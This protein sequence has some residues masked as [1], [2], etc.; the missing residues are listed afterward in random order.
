MTQ[1]TPTLSASAA[2]P[3]SKAV[4]LPF[5]P[6]YPGHLKVLVGSLARS[7]GPKSG[8]SDF[9]RA[10]KQCFDFL[11]RYWLA[12][13][14]GSALAQDP[15][16]SEPVASDQLLDRLHQ[17]IRDWDQRPNVAMKQVMRLGFFD[18]PAQANAAPVPKYHSAW[19]GLLPASDSDPQAS[20]DLGDWSAHESRI[21]SQK[22]LYLRVLASFL[23]SSRALFIKYQR[24]YVH[25]N[26]LQLSLSFDGK[27]KPFVIQ[28]NLPWL[29]Y[30]PDVTLETILS[31][32]QSQTLNLAPPE[33]RQV[34]TELQQA[35][36]DLLANQGLNEEP[37]MS[38]SEGGTAH[39]ASSSDFQSS[40][41]SIPNATFR[42]QAPLRYPEELFRVELQALNSCLERLTEESENERGDSKEQLGRLLT[43]IISEQIC[44]QIS[45]WKSIRQLL[46][47]E[48]QQLPTT[49][50][51]PELA[52]LH[53]E[54]DALVSDF[55]TYSGRSEG[56]SLQQAADLHQSVFNF[57]YDMG[58]PKPHALFFDLGHSGAQAQARLNRLENAE[59]E[60]LQDAL[61]A[62]E[63]CFA[64]LSEGW[65][66]GWKRRRDGATEGHYQ[67]LL[68][69][70]ILPV[71]LRTALPKEPMPSTCRFEVR[72][73]TEVFQDLQVLQQRGNPPH[74]VLDQVT[75]SLTQHHLPSQKVFLVGS[76]GVGKT[77][78]C[79]TLLEE[80][81]SLNLGNSSNSQLCC[82]VYADLK[83]R[84]WLDSLNEALGYH[85]WRGDSRWVPLSNPAMAD[86][87]HQTLRRDHST[88]ATA[89]PEKVPVE[90][91]QADLT[92][93]LNH[94][95]HSLWYRN[96]EMASV[97]RIVFLLDGL[98]LNGE[99]LHRLC[100]LELPETFSWVASVEQTPADLEINAKVKTFHLQVRDRPYQHY[101]L[102]Q[103][104]S[105][106]EAA[107]LQ[108]LVD[109]L[110]SGIPLLQLRL[111]CGLY[112][113]ELFPDP[114]QESSVRNLIE[115][116]V[117][118][119]SFSPEQLQ[120]L[121]CLAKFG[122]L[123]CQ[124]LEK[125]QGIRSEAVAYAVD[126]LPHMFLLSMETEG[127]TQE[128]WENRL[129]HLRLA[130][131]SLGPMLLDYLSV[132][133]FE[134]VSQFLESLLT[135]IE[136]QKD[137]PDYLDF[138]EFLEW[139]HRCNSAELNWRVLGVQKVRQ[140]R[141][142]VCED[143]ERQQRLFRKSVILSLWIRFLDN[144]PPLEAQEEANQALTELRREELL[145]AYSSRALAYRQLGHLEEALADV[146]LSL[147]SFKHAV[148]QDENLLNGLAAAHNRRSEILRDLGRFRE[149]LKDAQH[150]VTH[151]QTV[152]REASREYLEPL[153]A[154]AIHNRGVVQLE[155]GNLSDAEADLTAA[156]NHYRPWQDKVNSK[157][158]L[159]LAEAMRQ[160][161][162]LAILRGDPI[163]CRDDSS[164]ALTVLQR[165]EENWTELKVERARSEHQLAEAYLALEEH[166]Q[167]LLYSD[168][169]AETWE[170]LV[171]E[172]RLDLRSCFAEELNHR[173][174]LL[175]D[176][177]KLEE[178]SDVV[179][180]AVDLHRQL[181]EKEGR[182]DLAEDF[183][184]SLLLRG[185]VEEKADQLEA[186]KQDFVLA[187]TY[188]SEAAEGEAGY[189]RQTR[190]ALVETGI[191][192]T[193]LHLQLN[194]PEAASTQARA[195]MM[196]LDNETQQNSVVLEKKSKLW[197]LLGRSYL[198]TYRQTDQLQSKE[199]CL[200]AYT[201]AV[202]ILSELVD[203]QGEYHLLP[204]LAESQMARAKAGRL[205]GSNEASLQDC[206]SALELLTF[207]SEKGGDPGVLK[208]LGP[209]R[210]EAAVLLEE[211][212][213]FERS[214][215]NLDESLAFLELLDSDSESRLRQE[216]QAYRLQTQILIA[217]DK[218]TEAR[219]SLD[220]LLSHLERMRNR[221]WKVLD[222]LSAAEN[223]SA[224]LQ[225][226]V[227]T[228]QDLVSAGQ[229]WEDEDFPS[230]TS[231]EDL[232]HPIA[233]QQP[234]DEPSP[235]LES[236]PSPPSEIDVQG[237][238]PVAAFDQGI[239]LLEAEFRSDEELVRAVRESIESSFEHDTLNLESPDPTLA[240]PVK[241]SDE[242][243]VT[244]LPHGEQNHQFVPQVEPIP[245]DQH[246]QTFEE[247]SP[248]ISTDHELLQ[249]P[250]VGSSEVPANSLTE[251][252]SIDPEPQAHGHLEAYDEEIAQSKDQTHL[253]LEATDPPAHQEGGQDISSTPLDLLPEQDLNA[254]ELQF[255]QADDTVHS[256][257]M[258]WAPQLPSNAVDTF[259]SSEA[260]PVAGLDEKA[261]I[262]NPQFA[263]PDWQVHS[264]ASQWGNDLQA[265]SQHQEPLSMAEISQTPATTQAP[266]EQLPV[267]QAEQ[268]V[269]SEVPASE[270]SRIIEDDSV[271]SSVDTTT[272]LP[273]GEELLESVS[274]EASL[275]GALDPG[276]T[277]ILSHPRQLVAVGEYL[278]ALDAY[279]ELRDQSPEPLQAPW[280][281]AIQEELAVTA[282]AL[283][284]DGLLDYG[285][286]RHEVDLALH[287]VTSWGGPLLRQTQGQAVVDTLANLYE[288]RAGLHLD[289]G[290]HLAALCDWQ[291]AHSLWK[292]SSHPEGR[293]REIRMLAKISLGWQLHGDV[294][295]ELF[296]LHEL[297]EACRN[298]LGQS[299]GA[300]EQLQGWLTSAQERLCQLE[301]F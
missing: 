64:E 219:Q 97:Q 196:L 234:L 240:E 52:E 83:D 213:Q 25:H 59:D 150:A 120:F 283:F 106:L 287:R 299:L 254:P 84:F 146:E 205:L 8:E 186:A 203:G 158:R 125:G 175:L 151:Y 130:H 292:Y 258:D 71:H 79:T 48:S 45:L 105:H 182:R 46:R 247:A 192:L 1:E 204:T 163:Q 256:D 285:E 261:Q 165:F 265:P 149:S 236:D 211:L 296:A 102:E 7:I 73:L 31:W 62:C 221:N 136:S 23:S 276:L 286:C 272:A 12:A 115:F 16:G 75:E 277:A 246:Q 162:R 37:Q 291:T 51:K 21:N 209:A 181:V 61:S 92:Q 264:E 138:C 280:L 250:T 90:I 212:G 99:Q 229:L 11:I 248:D 210:L 273:C 81:R 88:Q 274:S 300:L 249:S 80:Q 187:C 144:L 190:D 77:F 60:T 195:T 33:L 44:I 176:L 152:I 198:V 270:S 232:D 164:R 126:L 288:L 3:A 85:H 202:E 255:G 86:I 179:K 173:S 194:D 223:F 174:K 199:A 167:A 98:E 253:E 101:L 121:T 284:R 122:S 87:G 41:E 189:R 5:D 135:Q 218:S 193:Y 140:R 224:Q 178:A 129:S 118:S 260:M 72:S 14:E 262:E 243:I 40:A 278:N 161:G 183:A 177:G 142:Q 53:H 38:Q 301:Q 20:S 96:R 298:D 259:A 132:D 39:P 244:T 275:S 145:W 117:N 55:D 228:Q 114:E 268:E 222:L 225:T 238:A 54:W 111:L 95:L 29:D 36:V 34:P 148:S 235:F 65:Q 242:T 297:C 207:L 230:Q 180:T 35:P 168:K 251:Q 112:Q 143:L 257:L 171:A 191:H 28:P 153:L 215:S 27:T 119:V 100:R 279:R 166:D 110:P 170:D 220:L 139:L 69:S 4:K 63:A 82:W 206:E 266:V 197:G 137:W 19:L 188:L 214:L 216:A 245:L 76:P 295:Q 109:K 26:A 184:K 56:L 15:P 208:L 108:K 89:L 17:A 6:S 200:D 237:Q 217:L 160:R 157:I 267:D 159:D 133:T 269:W 94:F 134:V 18:S 24:S 57:Y 32:E 2:Q 49:L 47:P 127:R 103:L 30:A 113:R 239:A 185:R 293:A 93:P 172:G 68:S 78:A 107:S 50:P 124:M 67:F 281:A 263:E 294:A 155:L 156:L 154:L 290:E 226:S 70:G 252:A 169:A 227:N 131:H 66:L 128:H 42:F 201:Q 9:P 141:E 282:V 123:P 241:T 91:S 10:I 231:F 13:L 58:Q 147:D 22:A 104:G 116:M 43:S 74:Y 233:S 271:P 289:I